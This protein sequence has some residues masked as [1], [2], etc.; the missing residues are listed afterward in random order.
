M[1]H[2]DRSL[3]RITRGRLALPAI[4]AGIP[5][6]TLV[7]VGAKSGSRRATPLLGIPHGDAIAV[8]GTQF[9]QPGTPSWYHNLRAN[10]RAELIYAGKSVAVEAREADGEE[11]QGI[12]DRGRTFYSGY[13]SYAERLGSRPIHIMILTEATG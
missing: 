6:L 11:W 12:W 13:D 4:A 9:G 7:T 2:V 5:V 8:I 1:P 10:P 3:L